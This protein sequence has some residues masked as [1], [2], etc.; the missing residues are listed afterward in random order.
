M[1]LSSF[2]GVPMSLRISIAAVLRLAK[3]AKG[4]KNEDFQNHLD[5]KHVNNLENAKVNPSLEILEA[6]AKPL[7][8]DPLA[9]IIFAACMDRDEPFEKVMADLKAGVDQLNAW[10]IAER[11]ND[12]FSAGALIPRVSGAQRTKEKTE[13]ILR[14]K[15]QGLNQKETSLK[16]N[17]PTS[18]VHRIWNLSLE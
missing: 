2:L 12:E 8:L 7:E 11:F 5:P 13:A 4:L 14:C 16:L 1:A 9:L 6:V 3:R 10:G 17:I 18:T 15:R